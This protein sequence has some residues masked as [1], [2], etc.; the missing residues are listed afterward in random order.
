MLYNVMCGTYP[1][2]EFGRWWM[3]PNMAS[4]TIST[5]C[6]KC[7]IFAYALFAYNPKAFANET[8]HGNSTVV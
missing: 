3:L 5:S 2:S 7:A 4:C 6:E 1:D 8:Q